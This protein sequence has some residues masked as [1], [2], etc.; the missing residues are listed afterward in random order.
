[1]VLRTICSEGY[2]WPKAIYI[3]NRKSEGLSGRGPK[4]RYS[5]FGLEINPKV[6]EGET[7]SRLSPS[8]N[9]RPK[10]DYCTRVFFRSDQQIKS[11][12]KPA[13]EANQNGARLIL[14]VT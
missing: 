14:V 6:N 2:K 8:Y 5:A 3:L 9:K 10:A 7:K 12:V 1:M 11:K 13:R 4:G